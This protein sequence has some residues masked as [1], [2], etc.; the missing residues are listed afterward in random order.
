MLQ[1]DYTPWNGYECR[2]C[3]FW[4]LLAR[5][6]MGWYHVDFLE[7]ALPSPSNL[8]ADRRRPDLHVVRPDTRLGHPNHR[9]GRSVDPKRG[10]LS[11]RRDLPHQPREQS[12][13]FLDSAPGVCRPYHDHT[14]HD[15]RLL[16]QGL[17]GLFNR[18]QRHD[19]RFGNAFIHG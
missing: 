18:Q 16:Y 17:L 4:R 15:V 12:S 6:R 14:V 5:W 9:S 2:V 13:R 19:R 3:R 1:R 11:I 10:F 7:S 8:L